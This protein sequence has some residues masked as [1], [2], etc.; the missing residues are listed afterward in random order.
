MALGTAEVSLLE[1]TGALASIRGGLSSVS[2][3]GISA[4]G[5]ENGAMRALRPPKADR[6]L[7]HQAEITE[8]LQEVVTEGTG[9]AASA[10]EGAAG[11][12]GTSQDYRDAWFVGFT[13]DLIAGVLGG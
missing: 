11:K 2:P 3:W 5:P 13:P 1:M 10:I 4:F 12:T 6:T 7:L 9:R 8:L